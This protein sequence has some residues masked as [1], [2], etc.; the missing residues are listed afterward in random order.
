MRSLALSSARSKTPTENEAEAEVNNEPMKFSTSKASHRTWRVDR[1]M[2]S[3]H[4]RPWWKV[5]PIS[6]FGTAFLLWCVLREETELDKQL[7]KQLHEQL[8][9]SDE[10]TEEDK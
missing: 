9:T 5:V 7:E 4:Q 2:G 10:E 8:S 1:S 3:Q 6:L